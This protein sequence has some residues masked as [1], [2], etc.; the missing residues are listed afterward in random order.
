MA[1]NEERIVGTHTCQ[2]CGKEFGITRRQ[3]RKLYCDSCREQHYRDA[4]REYKIANRDRVKAWAK[5]YNKIRRARNRKVYTCALCGK[6]FSPGTGGRCKYCIDCLWD[7]RYEYPYRGYLMN[8]K[9]YD[10]IIAR[11][12]VPKEPK[13]R[14]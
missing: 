2:I 13:E 5:E 9:E 11:K 14:T 12:R 7:K 6:E 10:E 1:D 8:R 4:K 3:G